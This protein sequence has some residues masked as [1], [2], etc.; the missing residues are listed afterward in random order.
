MCVPE[1]HL[2]RPLAGFTRDGTPTLANP[3]RTTTGHARQ[4][5]LPGKK[6][7]RANSGPPLALPVESAE[8]LTVRATSCPA[9]QHRVTTRRREIAAAPAGTAP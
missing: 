2:T 9:L 5:I 3:S 7:F 1:R 6:H 4:E 8:P